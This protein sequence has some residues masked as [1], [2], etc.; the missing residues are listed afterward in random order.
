MPES[1]DY[2]RRAV[3]AG[4]PGGAYLLTGSATTPR[5]VTV[6]SGAGRFIDLRMRPLS[7]FERGIDIPTVSLAGML[8]GSAETGGDGNRRDPT[9]L[10]ALFEHLVAL[11]VR[12]YAEAAEA[13]VSHLRTKGGAQEIDL[14]VE[15]RDGG[16]VALEVK[17]KAT[18]AESDFK[19]LDWLRE[20]IG[21]DLVDAAVITTGRHAYRRQQ[22]GFAVIPLSLLGP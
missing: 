7:F 9:M 17:L 22:D 8:G 11:S 20:Q 19:H 21:D 14:I 10:G 1:W 13:R 12:V 16:V 2:V 3:D 4:A 5:G 15:S 18:P 6:H